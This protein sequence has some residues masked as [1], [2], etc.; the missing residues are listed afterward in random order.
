VKVGVLAVG[1][2]ESGEGILSRCKEEHPLKR[3]L[4][5]RLGV[6]A[7]AHIDLEHE[8]RACLLIAE[9]WR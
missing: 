8:S 7:D 6:L 5:S 1:T 3:S 4:L 9:G 2:G